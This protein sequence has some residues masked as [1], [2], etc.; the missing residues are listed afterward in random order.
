MRPGT[1][2]RAW[3]RYCWLYTLLRRRNAS[4]AEKVQLRD[5]LNQVKRLLSAEKPPLSE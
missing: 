1:N 2:A 5:R 4:L 3:R